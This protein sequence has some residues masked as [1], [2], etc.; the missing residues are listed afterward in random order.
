M[1]ERD[2]IIKS[3]KELLP[4]CTDLQLL[5]LIQSLLSAND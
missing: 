1:E 3:I 5:Y 2:N 4:D